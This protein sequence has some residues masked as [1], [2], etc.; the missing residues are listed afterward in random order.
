MCRE[1]DNLCILLQNV[2]I[3][4][5]CRDRWEWRLDNNGEFTVRDL[6]ALV[7]GKI[8]RVE[9]DT[10]ETLWN[11]WLPKKVNIFVWRALKGRLPVREELDKRGIDLDSLLC[12]CCDSVVE[13]CT[14]SLV[15]C[16]L[17]LSVWEKIFN[18]WKVGNVN[19]FFVFEMFSNNGNV[20]VPNLSS[21]LWQTVVWTSG[22]YIWK[23][24]NERVFKGKVSS[25]NKIV[26]DIQLKSYEWIVR[27]STKKIELEW[28]QWL[29][30]PGKCRV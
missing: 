6:T 10:Q 7:E 30:D 11:K 12:P 8:L 21:R 2:V 19:A 13:T 17:A 26:Q 24:R 4:N 28:Q 5:D 1:F 3:S 27:R 20:A 16:N 25:S 18:W 29:F 14:H 9:N 23:E 22:Y 15:T